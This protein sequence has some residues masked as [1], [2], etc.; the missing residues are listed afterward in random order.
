MARQYFS[1]YRARGPRSPRLTLIWIG[2]FLFVLWA[3]HWLSSRSGQKGGADAVL[4]EYV[5][6]GRMEKV[7]DE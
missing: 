1:P 7:V 6:G 4:D 3:V 2:V 5:R